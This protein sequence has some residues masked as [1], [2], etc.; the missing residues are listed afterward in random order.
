MEVSNIP[1]LEFYDDVKV[2]LLTHIQKASDINNL[3][4]FILT[5]N[6]K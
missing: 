2:I 1:K 3:N 4:I 5:N 6:E